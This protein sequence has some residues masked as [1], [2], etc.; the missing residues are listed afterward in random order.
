MS[1]LDRLT[2]QGIRSFSPNDMSILEFHTP[3]T[4]I[5]GA[6]GTGKTT[7][8]ECLKYATTGSMPPGSRGGAFIYDPK[9]AGE[10]DVKAELHLRFVNNSNET[11]VCSRSM[12]SSFR[13]SRTEQKTLDSILTK[14]VNGR[15]IPVASKLSD[16]DRSVPDHLGVNPSI[17]ENVI[18]CHQDESTW[19]LGDLA[20]M[21]KKLDDIFS[22]T[23]YSKA[24]LGLKSS[25]KEISTDLKL[26]M[27]EASFLL[28]EKLKRDEV[29]KSIQQCRA[30][31]EKKS[32]K[33]KTFGEEVKRVSS[34]IAL[35]ENDLRLFEKLEQNHK[36]LAIELE[37]CR[38]FI[39]DFSLET[40]ADLDRESALRDI[41][42]LEKRLCDLSGAGIEEEFSNVERLRKTVMEEVSK[43]NAIWKSIEHNEAV[44]S[45]LVEEK[46]LLVGHLTI[47]FLCSE[48][49]LPEKSRAAFELIENSIQEKSG[50]IERDKERLFL[51]K[52]EQLEAEKALEE[53]RVFIEKYKDLKPSGVDIDCPVEIDYGRQ[54][55]LEA[56]VDELL[57]EADAKQSKLNE[58]YRLSEGAFK[59]THLLEDINRIRSILGREEPI[60][61]LESKITATSALLRDKLAALKSLEQEQQRLEAQNAQVRSSNL[62]ICR[63]IL[64]LLE[65]LDASKSL[66]ARLELLTPDS[67]KESFPYELLALETV[68]E[69][70]ILQ[71][72]LGECESIIATNAYASAIYTEL[73]KLGDEKDECPLCKRGM[74]CSE[75]AV[76][77]DE[78]ERIVSR[79]PES[80]E[81]TELKKAALIQAISDIRTQN[82]SLSHRN[83]IRLEIRNLIDGIKDEM[84]PVDLKDTMAMGKEIEEI[85]SSLTGMMHRMEQ[86]KFLSE[87]L[88]S[89]ESEY[90][91]LPD[92]V[93]LESIKKDLGRTK[94][95]LE[96]RKAELASFNADL[97]SRE[98][99]LRLIEAEK[100][101]IKIIQRRDEVAARHK[102]A[103][104]AEVEDLEKVIEKKGSE[105]EE[106]VKAFI[107]KK[108]EVEMK[109]SRLNQING[110]ILERRA[111]IL[112]SRNQ[113]VTNSTYVYFNSEKITTDA[114]KSEQEFERIR[115]IVMSYKN[116]II[117]LN[118]SL[119]MR[120]H[121]LKVIDENIKLR[122]AKERVFEIESELESF[123][124][125]RYAQLRAK[126]ASYTE[127]KTKLV[128]QESVARG[129]LK[130]LAHVL[131]SLN[132][133]IDSNYK[134]A[135]K[136]YLRSSIEIRTLELS[137]EDLE[138]CINGLD[139]AIVDFHGSKIEEINRA[140]RELWSGTY[141]GSD[142][143]YIEIRSESSEARAYNYRMVMV[144]SGVELDMRGRSSAGQ[145]MIAS[146]LFRIALADSFSCGCNILALDEPTT[147]LD[148]DNI[149][150]LAYT[151]LQIIKE[152]ADMQMIIITHDE[153]FVQ[154]L[155]REGT[156]YF[157]RLKRD[158]NGNG[159]IERHSVY[160]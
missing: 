45:E 90:A 60:D 153:E 19:P 120:K 56:I 93:D 52:S 127:R 29:A 70:D 88:R 136:N 50:G 22:S 12:Q 148:R 61:Q 54:V 47:E 62:R 42:L 32:Q 130:Q 15:S 7:I 118:R 1:R 119:N 31:I 142:I 77:M 64:S 89:L 103:G 145:K 49:E 72:E 59:K 41:E 80:V 147:N 112:R 123:D 106:L 154:L 69:V 38:R 125:K 134:D 20:V 83:H 150:G 117:E 129:E 138:K 155:N 35:L 75:K 5:V 55:E 66:R 24:L 122:K 152:R 79:I 96:E 33:L 105:L 57:E 11:L 140:L 13:K 71:T 58:A 87:Q 65:Q 108:T 121:D 27:H 97:K 25:K 40:L 81:A 14:E 114:L 53:H 34:S 2:I 102:S 99:R 160:K 104:S 100:E 146:I 46:R 86:S 141:K 139:K 17:L 111:E 115:S 92:S 144:K 30:E 48:D 128:D 151:L 133:R 4:L 98:E 16:V 143:D 124:A 51:L 137:L 107:R 26:K 94:A 18:F 44:L 37:S 39:K 8:I 110:S 3:L 6:N 78:L 76:F 157:Y 63:E 109:I 23:K 85:E 159:H 10:S 101:N 73:R 68:K 82:S 132:T 21:K 36:I 116:E 28:K 43:N 113:V 91:M 9:V 126:H 131:K 67:V 84:A 149:E 156:E 135:C 158:A 74:K 95:L